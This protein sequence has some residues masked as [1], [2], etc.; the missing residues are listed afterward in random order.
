MGNMRRKGVVKEETRLKVIDAASR[1][2]RKYGYAGVG[3]DALAKGAGVTSGAVYAH[4]GSKAGIFSTALEAG[5]NEVIE[6]L[7]V[8]QAKHGDGWLDEFIDYYLGAAHRKDTER[9]CAMASLTCE[10]IRFDGDVHG[11][12]E[13][14][15]QRIATLIAEGLRTSSADGTTMADGTTKAWMILS[16]LTGGLNIARAMG[17]ETTSEQIAKAVK[18]TAKALAKG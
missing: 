3:V 4:F 6:A 14:K 13:A 1:Q 15:M 11:L 9:V 16:L 5:L 18:D 8:L 12:Y 10:V 7:P 17:D 2:F